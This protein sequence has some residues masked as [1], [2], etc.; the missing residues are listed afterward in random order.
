MATTSTALVPL[1]D[2]DYLMKIVERNASDKADVL[3][4]LTGLEAKALSDVALVTAVEAVG[5]AWQHARNYINRFIVGH[6]PVFL[7]LQERIIA[8]R[9]AGKSPLII[10]GQPCDEFKKAITLLLDC[11]PSYFYKVVKKI[12]GKVVEKKALPEPATTVTEI[13]VDPEPDA[14]DAE[15]V[16]DNT[17]AMTNEMVERY[18]K[19]G[20]DAEVGEPDQPVA[21]PSD[22]SV[23]NI[24]EAASEPEPQDRGFGIFST[25]TPDQHEAVRAFVER[26]NEELRKLVGE[27]LEAVRVP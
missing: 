25:L 27:A 3:N 13:R 24:H 18:R 12:T 8:R 15:V 6:L 7:E 5:E 19:E 22:E 14:Q 16:D 4:P 20:M 23:A 11:D 1:G 26:R 21:M 17:K 10:N 2:R 9:R